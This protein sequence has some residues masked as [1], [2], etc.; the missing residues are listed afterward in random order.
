LCLFS[1]KER[2]FRDVSSHN[3]TGRLLTISIIVL[4]KRYDHPRK[5]DTLSA[6]RHASIRCHE[7][8]RAEMPHREERACGCSCRVRMPLFVPAPLLQ[9][10]AQVLI[11]KPRQYPPEG[12]G[13]EKAGAPPSLQQ[14]R[15]REICTAH[16]S[17]GALMQAFI[18][19][20]VPRRWASW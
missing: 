19:R 18:S 9:D 7:P 6:S 8:Y 13:E 5:K 17:E 12:Q 15:D 3:E 2:P 1:Q 10:I 16:A 4:H 11:G 20:H 14:D